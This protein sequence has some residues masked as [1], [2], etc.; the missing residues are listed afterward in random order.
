MVRPPNDAD[1][2]ALVQRSVL[3][4]LARQLFLSTDAAAERSTLLAALTRLFSVATAGRI[5]IVASLVHAG[6]VTAIPLPQAP[7]GRYSLAV[8]GVIVG[9]ALELV[10]RA[11]A[12]STSGTPAP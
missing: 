10:G 8:I 9:A 1:A 11:A 7:L 6:L 4:R 12:T 5:V 2:E 3:F